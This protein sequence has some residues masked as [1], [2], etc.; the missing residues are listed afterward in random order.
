MG[1]R[2]N[3]IYYALCIVLCI[4]GVGTTLTLAYLVH[5]TY[6]KWVATNDLGAFGITIVLGSSIVL[7]WILIA[8]IAMALSGEE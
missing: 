8:M 4:L 3:A 5:Q 1:S 6:Q 2:W 7:L